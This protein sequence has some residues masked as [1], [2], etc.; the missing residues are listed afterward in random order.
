MEAEH[1][2]RPAPCLRLSWF[3]LHESPGIILREVKGFLAKIRQRTE[4]L[5]TALSSSTNRSSSGPAHMMAIR[6]RPGK[7]A[8]R[9]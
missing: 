5:S 6:S 4:S 8:A 2:D 9:G 3:V 7:A 1:L